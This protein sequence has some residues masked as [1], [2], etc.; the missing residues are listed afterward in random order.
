MSNT[1][2]GEG[3]W[4]DY[5]NIWL[6]LFLSW[7]LLYADRAIT[8]PV[9]S[10]MIANQVGFMLEAPMPHAI[11]GIIGSMFFAGYMLTQFP[12]GHLGDR[13][14]HRVLIFISV[15]WS[16]IATL[17]NGLVKSLNSFV[18]L[19][20][21]T[22]LG[23][24]AYYSNDRAIICQV[25]P[26]KSRGLG[27]GIVFTGL[28]LGMTLAFV[29]TPM[30]IQ[31]GEQM[32]GEEAAWSLPF[33]IFAFPTLIMS[34]VLWK[35]FA[36]PSS[37]ILAAGKRMVSWAVVFL[38]VLMGVYL[39]SAELG[40]GAVSQ[41]IL[42]LT[43]A[44]ALIAFIYSS[45]GFVK[46]KA[47]KDRK[48]VMV[49]LSAIPLLYTLWFFGFWALLV[50][51]EASNM[52][53]PG[54][55]LYAALFGLASGIG[56][57]LGG[58]LCDCFGANRRRAVYILLCLS[59]VL[60]IIAIAWLVQGESPHPLALGVLLFI[61]GV[62]FAASQTANMALTADLSPAEERGSSFGM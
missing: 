19:R 61:M 50:V 45:R 31:A 20:I 9:V 35:V 16:G 46:S 47:L 8:G 21:I 13:Y 4:R 29:L 56:Y 15:L 5:H 1:N 53:L 10:W 17:L 34:F 18:A 57:P 60:A 24:G 43:A 2:S 59:V 51:A 40:L 49:Y 54:A 62:L 26:E 22:G 6:V 12:A 41:A 7:T 36:I 27:L 30:I 33:I 44:M 23:E 58:K 25:T 42:V 55:A 52:G 28:A 37:D 39:A 11:G 14:G 38:M 32:L 48:L 3:R